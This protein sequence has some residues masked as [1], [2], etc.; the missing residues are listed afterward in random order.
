[1]RIRRQ[2]EREPVTPSSSSRGVITERQKG[3]VPSVRVARQHEREPSYAVVEPGR[4]HGIA[5]A[6]S[7]VPFAVIM[8][9]VV[10]AE[11][12]VRSGSGGPQSSLRDLAALD[13]HGRSHPGIRTQI[14]VI[15]IT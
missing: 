1:M 13:D 7:G 10:I 12:C 11:L 14:S 6:D 2:R 3:A 4:D 9:L 15:R 5:C 8:V